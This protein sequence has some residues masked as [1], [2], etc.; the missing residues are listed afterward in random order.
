MHPDEGLEARVV[1]VPPS[2]KTAKTPDADQLG[3]VATWSVEFGYVSIH[4]PTAGEWFDLRTRDAPEWAVRE[5]RKRKELYRDG[6]RRAYRL[7]S[8]QM[9][10]ILE[11]ERPDPEVGIVEDHP[12]EEG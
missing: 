2:A 1:D 8:R 6:N 5:A 12:V 11:A 4:D 3:L 9:E 7:T 10:E